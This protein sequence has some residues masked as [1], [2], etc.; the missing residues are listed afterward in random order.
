MRIRA[1]GVMVAAMGCVM[2]PRASAQTPAAARLELPRPT[3]PYAVGT[4][5]WF[6]TDPSRVDTLDDGIVMRRRLKVAV[7]Y[8]APPNARGTR[9]PYL[10]SGAAELDV[11]MALTKRPVSDFA[12]VIDARSHALRGAPVIPNGRLP[13]VVLSHGYVMSPSLHTV[14][15]EELASRGY[16]VLAVAHTGEAS[17]VAFPD[18]KVVTILSRAGT[19]STRPSSVFPEWSAEDSSMT[20]VTSAATDSA[21]AATMRRYLRS[22]PMSTRALAR[23]TADVR[24][25]VDEA[26]RVAARPVV[27]AL[28]GNTSLLAGRLDTLALGAVGFSFGGITA[29]EFCRVDARCRAALNLDGIPQYG[30]M[31]DSGATRPSLVLYTE[32]P[33]RVGA[34]DVI[35]R[36]SRAPYWRVVLADSRHLD[37]SDWPLFGPPAQP[38]GRGTIEPRKAARLTALVTGEWFDQ[39][40]RGRRSALLSGTAKVDGL[41]VTPPNAPAQS[42]GSSATP[43]RS[44]V[45]AFY[46]AYEAVDTTR[47]FAA[48][49]DSVQLEDPGI[50]LH[51]RSKQELASTFRQYL[52]QNTMSQVRWDIRHRV[53]DGDWAVVEGSVSMTVN[54]V[55]QPR[56]VRFTTLLRFKQDKIIHHIDYIDYA[57]MRADQ[58]ARNWKVIDSLYASIAALK[59]GDTAAVDRLASFYADTA[60]YEDPTAG[61]REQ[62]RQR[63]R[64]TFAGTFLPGMLRDVTHMIDRRVVQNGWYVVEGTTTGVWKGQAYSSRFTAWHR[65][66]RGRIAHQLDYLDYRRVKS[67]APK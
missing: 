27:S 60:V 12:A 6:V 16:V 62:D 52:Q 22:L 31:L 66:A 3:G 55:P 58:Q 42:D 47:L 4:E 65:L 49:H 38:G 24:L 26:S 13:I 7:W 53:F 30:A 41:T 61:L 11:M 28:G 14:V 25:V 40:L 46:R 17:A 18:G 63:I 44:L 29:A 1:M 34:S 45:D 43:L 20:A 21:R 15:A 35:Y 37:A 2:M 9:A 56:P 39:Q 48:Y 36:N 5:D 67:A 10:R 8:P 59:E 19:V 33:G 32:R 51:A 50:Q 54:G 64:A 23:W 57:T